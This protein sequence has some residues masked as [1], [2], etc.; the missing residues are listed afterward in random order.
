MPSDSPI[1]SAVRLRGMAVGAG[2]S[3]R[4]VGEP[5]LNVQAASIVANSTLQ[6]NENAV[7]DIPFCTFIVQELHCTR[8][9]TRYAEHV[10]TYP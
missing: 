7:S 3:E 4:R 9:H 6:A 5:I 1:G 10:K 8:R 2:A